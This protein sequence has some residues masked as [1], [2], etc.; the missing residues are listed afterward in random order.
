MPALIDLTNQRFGK[1]V[2]LGI[3]EKNKYNKNNRLQWKCLCDCGV[4]CYK[5][6]DS[7][8]R[9]TKQG[10]KACTQKCGA[11]LPKGVKNNFLTIIEPI[12]VEGKPTKY[13]CRCDCGNITIITKQAFLSGDTK[14][15]GCYAKQRMSLIGK[16]YNPIKDITGIKFGKLTPKQPTDQR[17][18]KSVVWECLC[19]CGSTHYASLSNLSNGCVDRCSKC[20]CISRGEE[21]IAKI[22]SQFRIPF[23]QQKT[24][25]SCRFKDTLAKAKFDFFVDNNYIIEFDGVQ[26]FKSGEGWNTIEHFEKTK[27]HDKYKNQWCKEN[28]IPIIRI[29]YNKLDDL[30]IQDL[31]IETS[32]F[33]IE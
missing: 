11:L 20:S 9:V 23:V 26:H 15:C 16:Q 31:Q 2:V 25:E 30:T 18:G 22:L 14:S 24:F 7:L 17:Q 21:K 32:S 12:C 13:R 29:P 19:D 3:D 8:K 33:I 27:E 28:N 4:V 1:L 6:T 5:T 10:I